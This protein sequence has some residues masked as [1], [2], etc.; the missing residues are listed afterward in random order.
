GW[1]RGSSPMRIKRRQFLRVAAGSAAAAC[2][3]SL[4]PSTGGPAALTGQGSEA[5]WNA[6][7]AAARQEGNL[8]LNTMAGAVNRK[9][10]DAFEEA[11]PSIRV[12]HTT[13][14]TGSIWAPKVIQERDAGIHTWDVS[15]IPPNTAL[16]TLK[17]AGIWESVRPAI[18]SEEHT[19]EL[20]SPDHLVCRLLL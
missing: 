11:Y 5:D 3:P 10:V 18:R 13:Y 1:A 7:I 20:Q 17:P 8:T 4:S 9:A 16:T 12:E 15:Q 2:A 6:L 19:S 14:T